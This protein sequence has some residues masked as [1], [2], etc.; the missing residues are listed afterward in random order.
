MEGRS[1]HNKA[2]AVVGQLSRMAQDLQECSGDFKSSFKSRPA[3]RNRTSVSEAER[4]KTLRVCVVGAG[5]AGLRCAELLVEAGV[6][7]TVL[8]ARNRIGGRVSSLKA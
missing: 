3:I 4:A 5:L 1:H 2:Y 8:E 7:V 6:D